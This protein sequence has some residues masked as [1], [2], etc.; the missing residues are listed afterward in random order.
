MGVVL[1]DG[2]RKEIDQLEAAGKFA[3]AAAFRKANE[4]S[5]ESLAFQTSVPSEYQVLVANSAAFQAQKAHQ[6]DKAK[7]EREEGQEFNARLA[8][9][10]REELDAQVLRFTIDGEDIEI[11]RGDLRHAVKHRVEELED[12]RRELLRTSESPDELRKVNRLIAG[13]NP[14]AKD[15]DSER[16]TDA[17][18]VAGV[19]D[20]ITR[21]AQFAAELKHDH[22]ASIVENA[23]PVAG[24][25]SYASE[26]FSTGGVMAQPLTAVF[27]QNASPLAPVPAAPVTAPPPASPRAKDAL[28]AAGI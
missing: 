3:L 13:Y 17:N 20:A 10:R 28:Q 7:R 23:A 19:H 14:V 9:L 26:K 6:E 1:D 16:P 12:R 2:I 21:D 15:L 11:S 8:E 24:R 25:T 5:L 4:V 27:V 22:A 18:M